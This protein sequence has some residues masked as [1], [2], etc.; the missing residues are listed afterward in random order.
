MAQRLKNLAKLLSKSPTGP[1]IRG[2]FCQVRKEYRKLIKLKKLEWKNEMITKLESLE[3]KDPKEYWEMVNKLREKKKQSSTFNAT[4]FVKFFENL[5]AKNEPDKEIEDLVQDTL[6]SLYNTTPDFT[7]NEL[8]KAI[9]WLKNNKS[10]GPDRIPAE[11]L[12]IC[13]QHILEIFLLLMN[14]IK[15]SSQYPTNWALGITLSQ[16]LLTSTVWFPLEIIRIF[17]TR[18][19]LAMVE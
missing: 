16:K 4:D 1:Y 14:R 17:L 9:K 10:P 2:K 3:A 6:E 8:T 13:P 19:S 15:N 11:I 7:M 18:F 12:K 5:F